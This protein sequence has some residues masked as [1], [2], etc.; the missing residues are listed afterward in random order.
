MPMGSSTRY[1]GMDYL[2]FY[3]SVPCSAQCVFHI[4]TGLTQS[5]RE[6]L[7]KKKK[8]EEEDRWI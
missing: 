4:T 7:L 3:A 2:Q 5:D 6:G 8:V 1:Q